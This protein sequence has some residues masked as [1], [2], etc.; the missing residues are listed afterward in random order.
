MNDLNVETINRLLALGATEAKPL[1]L[2]NGEPLLLVPHG[3]SVESLAQF[4]PPS[5]IKQ[6]V[7]LLDAGSFSDYVNRFKG[8]GTVI[9]AQLSLTGGKFV[10][11]LDYHEPGVPDYCGHVAE[12]ELL[13]T[14]EWLAWMQSDRQPMDQVKF[15]EFIE[16]NM[17]LIAE[18]N[19]AELLE[20]I[21]DMEGSANARFE[22]GIKLESGAVKLNYVEDVEVRGATPGAI[23]LPKEIAADI[24][25]FQGMATVAVRARLKFAIAKPSLKLRYE[26]I[27]PHVIVREALL[28]VSKQIGEKTELVPFLGSV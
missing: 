12:F 20:L 13:N 18:P 22:R 6:R 11:M 15:A 16:E 3:V 2:A 14:P 25:P 27:T 26:T 10:A 24:A 17:R 21:T 9:F 19:S 1:L 5:R 4:L 7:K 23:A 28:A 8:A